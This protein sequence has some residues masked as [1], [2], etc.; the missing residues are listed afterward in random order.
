MTT[1]RICERIPPGILLEGMGSGQ[2][3]LAEYQ[4]ILQMKSIWYDEILYR[5]LLDPA[6]RRCARPCFRP[7][8]TCPGW[9]ST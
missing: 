7:P 2:A 6:R 1:L 4:E 8:R 5:N 3:N 9:P